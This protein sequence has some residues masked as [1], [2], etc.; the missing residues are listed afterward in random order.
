MQRLSSNTLPQLTKNL[1]SNLNVY[2]VIS[3]YIGSDF[4]ELITSLHPQD[5][6]IKVEST[7]KWDINLC[8]L[9][10]KT[11]YY[12]KVPSFL[13]VLEGCVW[14]ELQVG[15]EPV[16]PGFMLTQEIALE[17]AQP[18]VLFNTGMTKRNVILSVNKNIKVKDTPLL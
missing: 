16:N 5:N 1:S 7:G 15:K 14:T 12:N 13:K 6:I 10:P 18:H 2:K 3:Q 8:V 4:K 11:F 9:P 17:L